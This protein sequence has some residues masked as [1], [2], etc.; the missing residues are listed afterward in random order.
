MDQID[1]SA[2]LREVEERFGEH[3]EMAG[4][5]APLLMISILARML[6]KERE[7]NEYYEKVLKCRH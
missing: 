7:K 3:L 6:I 5:D 4:E 2:I 1:E